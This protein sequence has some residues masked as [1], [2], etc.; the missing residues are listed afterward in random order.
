MGSR[1]SSGARVDS[2]RGA[3]LDHLTAWSL[4]RFAAL[5]LTAVPGRSGRRYSSNAYWRTAKP[6]TERPGHAPNHE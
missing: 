6:S 1:K 4:P 2:A 3:L 5:N